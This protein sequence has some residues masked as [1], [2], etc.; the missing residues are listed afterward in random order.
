MS[1]IARAYT[2]FREKGFP[3][4][5]KAFFKYL[6]GLLSGICHL[7]RLTY[8]RLRG[9]CDFP[10]GKTHISLYVADNDDTRQ[11]FYVWRTEQR[12]IQEILN[13]LKPND[14]FWD[15][16]ANL[17]FYSLLAVSIPGVSVIAFEPNPVTAEKLRHN[18]AKYNNRVRVL[19]MA[20][21]D[22]ESTVKFETMGSRHRGRAHIA[23]DN[24]RNTIEVKTNSG[25]KLVATGAVPRP[26]V[27]KM[28]VEGAEY[29]VLKGMRSILSRCRVIFCEVHPQIRRYGSSAA[30]VE[31]IL[32]DAGFSLKKLQ[33]RGDNTY[34]L[35]ASNI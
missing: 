26:D 19:A 25:D 28:D 8:Y 4:L 27:V 15:I 35:K 20:L 24:D 33:E 2:V 9:K 1:I 13:E 6:G 21:A 14:I 10:A 18:I 34:H 32:E 5:L 17:G 16:G 11:L 31:S 30:E 3:A 23:F 29:L 12:L 7:P 22:S